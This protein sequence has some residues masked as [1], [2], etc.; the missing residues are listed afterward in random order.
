MPTF[1]IDIDTANRLL[2]EWANIAASIARQ[3][4]WRSQGKCL[5]TCQGLAVCKLDGLILVNAD[6]RPAAPASPPAH[7]T[8]SR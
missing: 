2:G 4:K 6:G 7:P 3:C 1:E 8:D 5:V